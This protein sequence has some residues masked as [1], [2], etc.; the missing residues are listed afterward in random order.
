MTKLIDLASP[1]KYATARLELEQFET[2]VHALRS[3]S[4]RGPHLSDAAVAAAR[5]VLVDGKRQADVARQLGH[6]RQQ[7]Y[8]W[9]RRI[10]NEHETL[11]NAH[12]SDQ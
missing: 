5:Q 2:T 10:Y 12:E 4:G 11:Q 1:Q 9:V 7:M 6:K 3:R 8:T